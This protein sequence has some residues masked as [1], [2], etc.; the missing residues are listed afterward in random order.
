MK[1]K[2]FPPQIDFAIL[3]NNTMKPVQFLIEHEEVL[4][5]QKHDSHP[6]FDDCGK[7]QFSISINGK[8]NDY[9]VKHLNS[10]PFK[11]VTLFQTKFITPTK[12]NNKSLHKQSLLLNDNDI[13]SD[14]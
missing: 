8:G 1:H 6:I 5:H 2:H 13:T 7:D 14:D 9:V 3:Q 4:Q 10:F 11:S 12:K